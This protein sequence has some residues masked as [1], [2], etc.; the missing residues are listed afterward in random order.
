MRTGARSRIVVAI[1]AVVAAILL[2]AAPAGA[3]PPPGYDETA[4]PAADPNPPGP[5]TEATIVDMIHTSGLYG[6]DVPTATAL[7]P[8]PTTGLENLRTVTTAQIVLD[9]PAATAGDPVL[10]YCIDLDT[11]TTIGIH[12][13]LSDW[14]LAN[15]PDL[16]YVQWI[17][18]NNYPHVP[19]APT[20]ATDAERVRA[21]QGA[22]WYFTDRFVVAPAYVAERAAVAAIV[23]AAQ[24]AVGP[25]PTPPVLPTLEV[26]PATR[27]AAV[28]GEVIGPF[29]IEGTVPGAQ[30]ERVNAPV[31]TDAA[32]T[33]EVPPGAT[34]A[35]GTELWM[36]FDPAVADQRFLL[37]AVALV[38]AGS[39][40]LYDGDNP[41]RTTAQKL[42]LA[43]DVAVPLRAVA[44]IVP[45]DAGALRVDIALSG[46]ASGSQGSI[47]LAA[48][49]SADGG[50]TLQRTLFVPAALSAGVS[51]VAQL[52]A[53]PAG[54]V[55]T[56][57]QTAT[58]ET[59]A[60]VLAASSVTPV[61][62]TIAADV[63]AVVTVADEFVAPA[64]GPAPSPSPSTLAEGGM[65][66]DAPWAAG[67]VLVVLGAVTFGL[68]APR[69]RR[70]RDTA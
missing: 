22:I 32:G 38:P 46:A 21:V 25:S 5:A 23:S 41:P 68:A 14:T 52:P 58:G 42:V 4:P 7:T 69:L 70:P 17:L 49:C 53:L 27:E 13:E 8:Y 28:P 11:E 30:V 9:D 45:E 29:V 44:T 65:A 56:V 24:A 63:T 47:E 3:T 54:A 60:A 19:T 34:L 16:P 50:W 15:V 48:S 64:P 57:V 1:G 33:V 39:V 31:Y 59:A 35:P 26:S 37:T 20:A 61:S 43:A 36:R 10:T 66:V 2:T 40:F 51:T 55:C 67:A 62:V 12:Y 6:G 18:E